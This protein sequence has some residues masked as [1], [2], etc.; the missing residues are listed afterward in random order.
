MPRSLSP[1]ST[2]ARRR[3]DAPS[4]NAMKKKRLTLSPAP[5]DYA[6]GGDLLRVLCVFMIGWYHIWQQSWLTPRLTLGQLALDVYPWVR[7]GY[8]FVDLM[9]L[10]SGFLTYLPWARGKGPTALQF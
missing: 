9:L 4:P 10:L 7:A 1:T 6:A 3:T 2:A 8:M 5:P